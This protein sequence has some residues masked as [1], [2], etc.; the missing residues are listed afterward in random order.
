MPLV[1]GRP[2]FR[3]TPK[4]KGGSGSSAGQFMANAAKQA[5]STM[6]DRIQRAT[7][8][9]ATRATAPRSTPAG[10]VQLFPFAE[11]P[12]SPVPPQTSLGSPVLQSLADERPMMITELTPSPPQ[13]S[14]PDSADYVPYDP[15]APPYFR[16]PGS[17]LDYLT[18]PSMQWIVQHP[19]TEST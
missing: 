10:E 8:S 13:V 2:A 17:Y 11:S 3:R 1:K 14:P 5:W 19:R 12:A 9:R 15:D 6:T 16:L 7:T 18:H 4:P